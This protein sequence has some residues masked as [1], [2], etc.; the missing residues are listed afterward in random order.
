MLSFGK[1]ILLLIVVVVA[2]VGFRLVSVVRTGAQA[3]QP[4]APAP[5][6]RQPASKAA[7][8]TACPVCGAY[9]DGRCDRP[10][11]GLAR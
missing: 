7:D 10:D 4:A 3:R 11:C 6:K 8:L 2:I 9:S 1:I 5:E